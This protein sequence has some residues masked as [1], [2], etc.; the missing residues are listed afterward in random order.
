MSDP[1]GLSPDPVPEPEPDPSTISG[2]TELVERQFDLLIDVSRSEVSFN[3]RE[4]DALYRERNRVLRRALTTRGLDSPFSWRTLRDWW[5]YCQPKWPTYRDRRDGLEAL[6]YP[7][8][9]ALEVLA[10]AAAELHDPGERLPAGSWAALNGR[11]AELKAEFAAARTLDGYQ[12]VARRSREILI[13][14]VNLAYDD[15]MCPADDEVPKGANA[16]RRFDQLVQST[17]GGSS[18]KD[19]RAWFNAS[20]DLAQKTTHA[21]SASE[22]TAF[23][24]GQSALTLARAIQMIG[25]SRAR[26]HHQA[27][28]SVPPQNR[29]VEPGDQE[30][31]EESQVPPLDDQLAPDEERLLH[32]WYHTDGPERGIPPF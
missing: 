5:N 30:E 16:K 12:D 29:P 23:A 7:L 6:V 14:A 15:S 27:E 32:E 2:L 10:D 3:D 19:T 22:V 1:W 17:F 28:D 26:E 9:D 25:L 21:A 4:K 13:D 20:W 31:M 11:I 18:A 24:T 8:L